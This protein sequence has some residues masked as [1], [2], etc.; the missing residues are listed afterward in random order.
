MEQ[1]PSEWEVSPALLPA[2]AGCL[3]RAV[4]GRTVMRLSITLSA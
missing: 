4:S 3:A 2:L 1:A